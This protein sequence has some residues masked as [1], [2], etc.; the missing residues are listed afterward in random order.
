MIKL[1]P[2]QT[3]Q[4]WQEVNRIQGMAYSQELVEDLE[5]LK[6]KAV[7]AGHFCSLIQDVDSS[8]IIGYV[9]AHPYPGDEVP[10]LN[11]NELKLPKADEKNV[12]LHDM[13]LDPSCSGQG[14]G[15]ATI[16]LLVEKVR[17]SGCSSM[18]LVAVQSSS[19]FW[20]KVAGFE[21]TRISDDKD[22]EK[23]GAGA[24]TMQLKF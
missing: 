14:V 10:P 19:D 23:Y 3:E 4:D 22:L 13:A 24:K 21:C 17:A 1:T 18:T 2:I 6:Q 20:N 5:A 9:L 12:F 11:S 8:C 15:K 16:N 7:I